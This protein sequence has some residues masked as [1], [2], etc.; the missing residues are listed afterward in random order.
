MSDAMELHPFDDP[1]GNPEEYNKLVCEWLKTAQLQKVTIELF[2]PGYK[3][4]EGTYS[5]WHARNVGPANLPLCQGGGELPGDAI[6]DL[7]SCVA[8]PEA[9]E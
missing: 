4:P 5:G 1:T 3:F 6:N 8:T 7:L 2:L 9:A